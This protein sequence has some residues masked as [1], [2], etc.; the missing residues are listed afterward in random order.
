M[1]TLKTEL[2]C[3]SC[4]SNRVTLT[5]EQMFMA[6]TL[7]HYCHSVKIQDDEAKSSCLNC[8]WDGNRRCLEEKMTQALKR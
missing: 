4:G 3:P 2:V 5:A 1:N 7:E 8:G 6:N